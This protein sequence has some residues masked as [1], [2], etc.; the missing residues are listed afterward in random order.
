MKTLKKIAVFSICSMWMPSPNPSSLFMP[1]SDTMALVMLVSN[2]A[3]TVSNTLKILE[4]AK[5]TSQQI[6]KYNYMAMRRF[7]IARRIEH[8]V[9]DILEARKMRP[10]G[11]K[12]INRLMLR[13]KTNL[14]HLKS[15]IDLLAKDVV[16]A[17]DFLE[18]H[19]GK[20]A[21][22]LD[23]EKEVR[24]QESASASDGT[25]SK[26]VQNTAM[27]TALS[28]KILSQIRRNQLDYQQTDLQLKKNEKLEKFRREAVYREW[29]NLHSDFESI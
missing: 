3:S 5:K 23:D 26:H 13:L 9:Q 29:L 28:G 1:D 21:L 14:R 4:V 27:N 22:A 7:F 6:D 10:K 16:A 24:L 15:N 2:T 17:R 18:R 19:H 12:E 20:M 25:M 11:L 8:H